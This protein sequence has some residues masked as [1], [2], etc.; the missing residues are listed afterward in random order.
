MH[1][2]LIDIYIYYLHSNYMCIC[3]QLISMYIHIR[4]HLCTSVKKIKSISLTIQPM[5][6]TFQ[7]NRAATCLDCEKAPGDPPQG[8][9][10][11]PSGHGRDQ[12]S[13]EN[14]GNPGE[15]DS[16]THGKH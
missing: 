7:N 1:I 11:A 8:R 15:F 16:K 12:F 6:K 3:Y 14:H 13:G 2:L 5:S 4:I 10:R 9:Y